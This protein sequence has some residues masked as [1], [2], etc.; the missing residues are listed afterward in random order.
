MTFLTML[1][2]VDCWTKYRSL[3]NDKS[4]VWAVEC[5]VYL[6]MHEKGGSNL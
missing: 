4:I 1:T 3:G 6:W 2:L 5:N